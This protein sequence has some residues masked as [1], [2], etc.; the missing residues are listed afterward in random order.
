M[1]RI[2]EAKE[3]FEKAAE[4][5]P[6]FGLIYVQKCYANYRYGASKKDI[7]LMARAMSDFQKAFEKFPDCS[8]CYTLYAQVLF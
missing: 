2:K 3:D 5:H 7:G 8:E 6:D 1:E 4:L